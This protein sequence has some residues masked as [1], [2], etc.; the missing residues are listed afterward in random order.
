MPPTPP[1]MPAQKISSDC[2][3]SPRTSWAIVGAE[4]DRQRSADQ[5]QERDPQDSGAE[6]LLG[7][8]GDDVAV[9]F[10]VEVGLVAGILVVGLAEGPP[11]RPRLGEDVEYLGDQA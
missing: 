6:A 10:A 8:V 11:Q 9:V 2:E 4:D 1:R 5:A 3:R 7:R